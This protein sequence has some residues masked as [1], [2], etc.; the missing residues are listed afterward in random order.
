ML[1]VTGVM[2]GDNP[3]DMNSGEH[4]KLKMSTIKYKLATIFVIA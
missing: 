1:L 2:T 3:S 4:F